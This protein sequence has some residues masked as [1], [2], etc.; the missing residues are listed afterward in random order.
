IKEYITAASNALEAGFDG[1]EIHGANGYLI[2]QFLSPISNLRK[3]DYGGSI[4]K[5][6]WFLLDIV[7]GV[8]A[9]IGKD[10]VGIRLSP[11]GVAS[12][13]TYYPE[14]KETFIYLA[15]KLNDLKILYIHLA[16][17]SSLGAP[18]VPPEIKTIIRNK[19]ANTLILS[20]GYT[21]ESAEADLKS[22]LANLIAF[23]RSFINN[24]D[25]VDR[26]TNGWKLLK[27]LDMNTFYTP[28]EKGYT[29][30]PQHPAIDMLA[31]VPESI[32]E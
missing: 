5:R 9:A 2:E 8:S 28:G 25:L 14:T 3:D 23:G 24:P 19:F 17:H 29:D 11:Y 10:K 7:E 16:D 4:E 1:V 18:V 30:Y 21:F 12:D 26:F 13:M 15:E 6:C 27:E 31:P 32:R 20:G 22:E